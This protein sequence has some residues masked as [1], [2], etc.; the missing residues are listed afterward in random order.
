MVSLVQ[1]VPES[2]LRA[3]VFEFAGNAVA[4]NFQASCKAGKLPGREDDQLRE[5]MELLRA[6]LRPLLQGELQL[7][8][9]ALPKMR[10]LSETACSAGSLAER[11][12][13]TPRS[14][15]RR[16]GTLQAGRSHPASQPSSGD[17]GARGPNLKRFLSSQCGHFH[18]RLYCKVTRGASAQAACAIQHRF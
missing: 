3:I 14:S 11:R 2:L 13:T 10:Q 7:P 12:T 8:Y 18:L 15:S 6:A 1:A 9:L 5:A 4:L 17:N 16:R